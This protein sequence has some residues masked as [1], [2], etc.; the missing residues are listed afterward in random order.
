MTHLVAR[1]LGLASSKLFCRLP[2]AYRIFAIKFKLSCSWVRSHYRT[3]EVTG[4]CT[5]CNRS[6]A[7]QISDR[8]RDPSDEIP[9]HEINMMTNMTNLS[10]LSFKFTTADL[11]SLGTSR[12]MLR[13]PWLG[14][15][16]SNNNHSYLFN[17]FINTT[18]VV[19][20][21]V[22]IVII[23]IIITTAAAAAVVVGVLEDIS[24]AWR[25]LDHTFYSLYPWPWS[26]DSRP[27]PCSWVTSL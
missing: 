2:V 3:Q 8:Q 19:V 17:G 16:V 25:I 14:L 4:R 22:I 21:V 1:A 27:W 24:L 23:I 7:H 18:I 12:S 9:V 11:S 20:V 6:A 13:Q 5:N 26:C 15:A 10:S